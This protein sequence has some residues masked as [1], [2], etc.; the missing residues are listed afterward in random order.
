MAI[1][2]IAYTDV[3]VRMWRKLGQDQFTLHFLG[4]EPNGKMRGEFR[5]LV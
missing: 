1:Q 4:R 3:L 5:P 2:R